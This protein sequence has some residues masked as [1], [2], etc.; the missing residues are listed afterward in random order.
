ML[1]TLTCDQK[2][3][4]DNLLSWQEKPKKPFITFGGFAGTGKTT[5]I[6]V[7]RKVLSRK[8]PKLKVVFCSYTGKASRVLQA[9]LLSFQCIFKQD[10]VSTIHS[11]IYEPIDDERGNAIAWRKKEEVKAD[12]IIVDEASMMDERIW[13]DLLSFKIPILAVGDHGQLPPINGQFN[14]MQKPDMTLTK[15]HRQ[16]QDS[17]II[18]LSQIVRE[19][20]KIPV[21]NFGQGV[22]KYSRTDPDIYD[23]MQNLLQSWNEETLFLVGMNHNRIKINN[24]IRA[25]FFDLYELDKNPVVGDRLICLR[26]NW[27][28]GIYNGMMGKIISLEEERDKRG[29]LHWFLVDLKMDDNSTFTGKISAYQFNNA[30]KIN[31]IEGI[32]YRQIGELFDFGY[33][34]TVHKAQGSQARKVILFEERNKHMSDEQWQRWLYTAVTRAQ[35]ELIVVGD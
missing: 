31:S 5:L 8:N 14:L 22:V 35:E 27:Q 30:N 10:R 3:V 23:L 33:C 34:L 28:K 18:A 26:N 25:N 24:Q 16:A 20:G 6:S 2:Q 32:S 7:F 17:P 12:L 1:F 9:N 21:K 13:Q 15:I 29:N 4:L 19:T 11:L